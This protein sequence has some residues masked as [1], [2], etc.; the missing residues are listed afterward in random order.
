MGSSVSI[1]VIQSMFYCFATL[2]FFICIFLSKVNFWPI[3]FICCDIAH[4]QCIL[5]QIYPCMNVVC[6]VG[7]PLVCWY[8]SSSS[9]STTYVILK[10]FTHG[11]GNF[12]NFPYHTEWGMIIR[13]CCVI[14]S[15]LTKMYTCTIYLNAYQ[16]PWN[17]T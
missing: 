17:D 9:Y 10:T 16:T 11:F 15:C 7:Y 8:S 2:G 14:S 4:K 5:N 3:F 12:W 1:W 6:G 13:I